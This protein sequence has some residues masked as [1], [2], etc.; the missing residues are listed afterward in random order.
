MYSF[1]VVCDSL[2][3]VCFFF[4]QAED[5]IRDRN[6]TG[7][8]TCALPISPRRGLAKKPWMSRFLCSEPIV[9]SSPLSELIETDPTGSA[10]GT[11]GGA[12]RDGPAVRGTVS[13]SRAKG[14]GSARRGPAIPRA[15]ARRIRRGGTSLGPGP[16]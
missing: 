8:Q 14:R 13:A 3:L 11:R 9:V 5:G 12:A 4:F 16:P 7:V 6:V 10:A 1:R 2:V 15:S